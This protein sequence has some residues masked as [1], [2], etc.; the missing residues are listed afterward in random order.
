[1]IFL[2]FPITQLSHLLLDHPTVGGALQTLFLLLVVWWAWQYT[3]WFTNW[4]DS[5]AFLVRLTLVGAML[6]SLMMS[7][8]IPGAFGEQGLMF[9]LAYVA[10]QVGRTAF[11]VL[12]LGSSHP[13]SGGFRRIL[14]WFAAAGVVWVA[15]GW[16]KARRAMPCGY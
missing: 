15:G 16:S 10:I 12:A 1:M 11:A 5:D 8:A 13:L 4:F 14:A 7:V 9:S 6:A 3:T 2:R